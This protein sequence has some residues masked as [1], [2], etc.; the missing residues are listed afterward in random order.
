M[1]SKDT[2]D[3]Q[4]AN[5]EVNEKLQIGTIVEKVA[6][7]IEKNTKPL[8]IGLG[9]VVVVIGALCS[10]FFLYLPSQNNQAADAMFAAEQ[11]Y[12]QRDYDKALKGDGKNQG[13]ISVGDEYSSTKSGKLAKYYTGRI[14]MEQ[15][16]FREAIPYLKAYNPDDEYMSA[17]VKSLIADC[18]IELNQ[19]SDAIDNYKKA[20]SI[21][22]N[23]FNTPAILMKL[24]AAYEMT[25]DY[26]SALQ[27]YK[28]IKQDYPASPEF[29]EVEKYISRMEEMI[30]K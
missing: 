12:I 19:M 16:K 25:K 6:M 30:A 22:P 1:N 24:A 5:P 8:L 26:N 2:Q 15:G 29:R 28:T 11:Y 3:K 14:Y 4:N 9:V 23:D 17:Q 27:T 13:F 18:N 7:F 10:Y 20:A 21:H